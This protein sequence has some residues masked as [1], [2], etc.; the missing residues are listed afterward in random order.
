MLISDR[1]LGGGSTDK[2]D[3][4]RGHGDPMCVYQFMH[5]NSTSAHATFIPPKGYLYTP[6]TPL[7]LLLM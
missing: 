6:P 7:T 3:G 5:K 2:E 4:T 1:L